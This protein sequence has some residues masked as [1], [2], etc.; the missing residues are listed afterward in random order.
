MRTKIFVGIM[1]AML[2][3]PFLIAEARV[4]E[5]I[6]T[7]TESPTFGGLSFDS[8]GQYEK[9]VGIVKGELDPNDPLN[10]GIV[11]I[12]KAPRNTRGFVEY[13]ADIYIFKPVNLKKG[14][15]R[16]L[17]DVLNRGNKGAHSTYNNGLG[18][19][20]PTTADDAGIGFLM[21]EGYVFM[22]SG[23]QGS[24]YIPGQYSQAL[25]GSGGDRMFIRLPSAPVQGVNREEFIPDEA[26][27]NIKYV[28][29]IKIIGNLSYPAADMNPAL[30]TL[31]IREHQADARQTPAGMT[32]Q[33][34]NNL[35]IEIMR[36]AGF[37]DGAIYEFI[38]PSKD[39]V[40]YG[41]AFAS[42]RDALSFLRYEVYDD[43]GRPNP[44]APEG[45]LS[46]E[47]V[48]GYGAS[49]SGRYLKNLIYEGFNQDENGRMVFDGAIS[50]IGGSRDNWLNFAFAQPGCWS[51]QHETHFQV[52]DQFPFT[53]KV[54][55]DPI[56][57]LTGGLLV[58][59]AATGTCPK[60]MQTDTE[61]EMYQA[62]ASL[63]Y[64]DTMGNDITL[65]EN[66][67]AYEFTACQHSANSSTAPGNC[68]YLRNP[69]DY[70][71]LQRALLVALDE[72]VTY[73]TKPPDNQHPTRAS[74]TLVTSANVGFPN[75]PGV[76]YTGLY[77]WLRLTNYNVQPPAE[78]A[79]YPVF[80]PKVDS[81]GN[82]VAGIRLPEVEVPLA[83]YTGW[84]LRAP[85]YAEN[86]L[87]SGNG[88]Y[89]PFAQTKAERLATGD[90]RPSIEERYP[91]HGTYV[92][93]VARAVNK[94]VNKRLLLQEDAVRY[95]KAAA[96]GSLGKPQE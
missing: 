96:Q 69:L 67:R 62:R 78:Y 31:T 77:N 76:T 37:D 64:T 86:D 7:S 41:V 91:N 55:Y 38:Y 32:W 44:L 48:Y 17:Y 13:N 71:P 56:S 84:N 53:Y 90:P 49:Q 20:N 9:L 1:V 70:R 4:T 63:V 10:A 14:N 89:F 18:G 23:W 21:R 95:K 60:I 8:V 2:L 83:T 45:I 61:L 81:D 59:C 82:G 68:K 75:I 36:P 29:A 43:A 5:V 22:W 52:N 24:Y 28:D 40:V 58:K 88:S 46:I 72:W 25:V 11:N 39:P 6:I 66:V 26:S 94:L 42:T 74:G 47:K 16:I 35:Q 54:L 65:P 50:H 87:C 79:Y 34:L 80:L 3:I 85:G 15:G 19:N 30:A 73:G 33:Y 51:R 57:G 93:A 12:D 92:N 27:R